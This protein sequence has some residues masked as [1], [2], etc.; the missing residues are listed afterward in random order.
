MANIDKISRCLIGTVAH[1]QH[2]RNI[3]R[4]M[5]E[6]GSLGAFYTGGVDLFKSTGMRLIRSL[7]SNVYSPLD[8]RLARRRVPDVPADLIFSHWGWEGPRLAARYLGLGARIVDRLWEQSE[9]SLDRRC[10]SL[11]RDDQFDAYLG[12]E[13]G[14]LSS[15]QSARALGKPGIVAFFS[16]HYSA[17]A[18]WVDPEYERFPELLTPATR[19]IRQLAKARDARR[20]EEARM[21]DLVHCA[22]MF[23]AQSLLRA[24]VVTR[25]RM[26]IVPLGCP[27]IPPDLQIPVSK[28]RPVRFVCSGTVA[29][30]KGTHI[31]LEAWKRLRPGHSA[32]LHLYGAVTVPKSFCGPADDSV[33]F[34]GHV[35]SAELSQAYQESAML[36]FPTLCDGF[37]MVV[38]EAFAHGLPVITTRNAGAADLVR[39]GE[40]GYVIPARDADSLAERLAWCIDHPEELRAM[41]PQARQTALDWQWQDFRS[42]FSAQFNERL[43]APRAREA[44]V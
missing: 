36:V 23:T 18:E 38:A 34:H 13:H 21:A 19:K 14:A 11:L 43:K 8:G 30:H 1:N 2:I 41:R 17:R 26:T 20:D 7:A 35:G 28:I 39:E 44:R 15:L 22:S 9:L 6:G 33:V 27:E 32:E 31:L 24:G 29:V 40:N 37:G 16:P 5:H 10:A 25:D 4:A 12:V 3:A 42:L